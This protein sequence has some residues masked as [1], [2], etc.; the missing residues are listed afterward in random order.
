M[1]EGTTP[2]ETPKHSFKNFDEARKWAKENIVGTYRNDNTGE[3]ISVSR[4]AIDKYMSASAVLKSVNK[5]AHMSALK[6]IPELLKT[7]LL[8]ESNKDRDDDYHIKEIQ[9]LYGAISYEGKTYPVKITVKATKNEGNKAYSYEVIQIESPIEHE[10][11]SGQSTS[12]GQ[13]NASASK[14]QYTFPHLS[15]ST[16]SGQQNVSENSSE[17]FPHS[18]ISTSKDTNISETAKENSQNPGARFQITPQQKRQY[19][20][21]ELKL[22]TDQ[23]ASPE[24]PTTP[25]KKIQGR[26]TDVIEAW[27]DKHQRLYNTI[28]EIE[29]RTGAKV[30][31]KDNPYD[32]LTKLSARAQAALE[33]FKNKTFTPLLARIAAMAKKIPEV[34]GSATVQKHAAIAKTS[35]FIQLFFTTDSD[36]AFDAKDSIRRTFDFYMMAKHA[37]HRNA[38]IEKKTDGKVKDGSG[39]TNEEAAAVVDIF[40]S[41]FTAKEISDFWKDVEKATD[42][43]L[44]AWL[45]TGRITKETRDELKKELP[46]FV[47]LRS[48]DDSETDRAIDAVYSGGGNDT[49]SAYR[50]AQGRASIA[51]SP[52][53]YIA[54]LAQSA[55]VFKQ[56]NDVNR[57][58]FNMAAKAKQPDLMG[59]KK[60]YTIETLDAAGNVVATRETVTDPRT[61]PAHP[62]APNERVKTKSMGTKNAISPYLATQHEV[63]A[64]INGKKYIVEF[65]D[66][67]VAREINENTNAVAQAL[68]NTIG[69]V[70]KTMSALMTQKNPVFWTKNTFRDVQGAAIRLWVMHDG[71]L[72]GKFLQNVPRATQV[73]FMAQ[74]ADKQTGAHSNNP[75]TQKY[76]DYYNE[77]RKSGSRVGFMQMLDIGKIKKDINNALKHAG[78][79]NNRNFLK[80]AMRSINGMAAVSE[81]I[82]RLAAFI[83]AR[84]TGR[85]VT[86]ASNIAKEVTVNFNRSGKYS[87]IAGAFYAFFNATVQA[88]ANHAEMFK[89]HPVKASVAA[90]IH[91]ALGYA[92]YMLAS[93]LLTSDDDDDELRNFSNYRKYINLFLPVGD[94]GFAQLPLSQTWRPFYA[95]G[96]A[97]EQVQEGELTTKEAL[98]GVYEQFSNISPV[99]I[100]GNWEQLFPTAITPL[101][102]TLITKRNYMGVPLV[103]Y[104]YNDPDGKEIPY[105]LRGVRTDQLPLWQHIV[106]MLVS[107]DKSTGRTTYNDTVT[108]L[109]E[110]LSGIDISPD[111]LQHLV[112]SY[113]GGLGSAINDVVNLTY[114]LI[115]GGKKS[116]NK[117]PIVSSYYSESKPGYY[118]DKYYRMK[119][120]YDQFYANFK[121]DMKTGRIREYV[122]NPNLYK[123][124]NIKPN[125]QTGRMYIDNTR[126][127]A[128]HKLYQIW[129]AQDKKMRNFSY[130]D[131]IGAKDRDEIRKEVERIS[132][133]T[134]QRVEPVFRELGIK[135]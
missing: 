64:W 78:E 68:Q 50:E 49:Y 39:I 4:T 12:S 20:A 18:D 123:L 63:E 95:L 54:N 89:K 34:W 70:T 119:E 135:Y 111:Q 103:D 21:D 96:V 60:I 65:A 107:G 32:R 11:L 6:V 16:Q 62:L 29:K 44:N 127:K 110:E 134:V 15:V 131:I 36:V 93:W 1:L 84:E 80:K 51:D 71:K 124:L 55:I 122:D 102:E 67:Q 120:I 26:G 43:S 30:E 75:A 118:T 24:P 13:W 85:D 91:A 128:L 48:W 126:E 100:S 101:I 58:L 87:G 66:E 108:A 10:E 104:V 116:P 53:A 72:A 73:A 130:S 25:A 129:D 69:R 77:Y 114:S 41:Q 3:N 115:T 76:I 7:S 28:K 37:P 23:L 125:M 81:D 46:Y 97:A 112:I 57:M 99:E 59:T 82:S 47:P 61:D 133:E 98:A 121:F 9:R 52:L 74:F 79:V 19:Y 88:A 109:P 2:I 33:D 132:K 31:A 86:E 106:D 105:Y 17:A 8:K 56:K 14:D 22:T 113:T 92:M 83:A 94:N 27:V 117:M 42:T 38:Y 90:A 40:E 5:N 35:P 45:N